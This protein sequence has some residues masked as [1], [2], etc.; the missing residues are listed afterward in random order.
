MCE[1]SEIVLN[2]FRLRTEA[3]IV[4]YPDRYADP[5]G[6]RMWET[7]WRLLPAPW[8][9][10]FDPEPDADTCSDSQHPARYANDT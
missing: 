2:G 5:R 7:V 10:G 1:A 8:D 9:V 4:R 6:E 3:Q